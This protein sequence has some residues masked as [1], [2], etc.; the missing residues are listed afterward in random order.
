MTLKILVQNPIVRRLFTPELGD[1]ALRDLVF[2]LRWL[3]REGQTLWLICPL[4]GRI[5]PNLIKR[6][7]GR[8]AATITGGRGR[9]VGPFV[10]FGRVSVALAQEEKPD[11]ASIEAAPRRNHQ[12]RAPLIRLLGP[13]KEELGLA[14]ADESRAAAAIFG[15]DLVERSSGCPM[16]CQIMDYGRWRF[17]QSKRERAQKPAPRRKTVRIR[18]RCEGA[19][20]ARKLRAA[21]VFLTK[22]V[23]VRIQVLARGRDRLERHP[24]LIEGIKGALWAFG[25]LSQ[26]RP[27]PR[28]IEMDFKP[29]PALRP[30]A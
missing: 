25:A 1:G 24:D 19:D 27:N 30:W 14:T 23:P 11:E 3:V 17:Q 20:L 21:Q 8:I 18:V 12:V 29:W 26:R 7:L 6:D 16:T 15:L 4:D 13:N 22:R 2:K 10:G 28:R 5:D 9:R